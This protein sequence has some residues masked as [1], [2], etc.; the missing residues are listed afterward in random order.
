MSLAG[1]SPG[2]WLADTLV[3]A[4]LLAWYVGARHLPEFVLPGPVAVFQRLVVLF[5]DPDF[6]QHT[7]ASTLRVVASVL[8]ALVIG[9]GLALLHRAVPALDWVIRGGIQPMLSSFPSIG[10]AILAAIWFP[11]GHLS[12]IFVQVAILIPFCLINMAEGLRQMDR[13][14][15]EMARSYT[16]LG[17][18]VVLRIA[19]P[20]IMP[21]VIGALRICY[22]I[23]WKISLVAELLGSSSGLGFLM[24]RA[25]GAA[26]MTTVVAAS[27][28]IVLLFVAGEK[29][30]IAPLARR[31]APR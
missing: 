26:D 27:F 3:L 4:A 20:L 1:R 19:L 23:G 25:Q 17:R 2:R 9:G 8:A 13:E 12:I 24:L 14:M 11:P 29:L 5:V 22:G 16:R 15:L 28:A 6:L 31:Y 18:R 10:W 7:L 30:L 21:Y